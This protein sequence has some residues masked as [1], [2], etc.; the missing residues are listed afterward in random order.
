MAKFR[1]LAIISASINI[2]APNLVER[3]SKI[4]FLSTGTPWDADYPSL[5]NFFCENVD[6]RRNY[7]AK[8][9]SKIVGKIHQ[10]YFT[11]NHSPGN[12]EAPPHSLENIVAFPITA[13]VQ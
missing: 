10:F 8:S 6:R 13:L 11:V 3:F 9:K 12:I 2:F 7:G 5:Y 4:R 1:F